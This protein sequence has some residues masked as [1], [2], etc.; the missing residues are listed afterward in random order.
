VHYTTTAE[1]KGER[2][3]KIGQHL[4][5]LW[6]S[7][8]WVFFSEHSV[9]IVTVDLRTC[10]LGLSASE[11]QKYAVVHERVAGVD[12]PTI[13]CSGA[14]RTRPVYLS[15]SNSI[16][17]DTFGGATAAHGD[18]TDDVIDNKSRFLLK[19]QGRPASEYHVRQNKPVF[20]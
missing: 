6:A 9:V 12:R 17:I 1:S 14:L 4:P 8:K 11:C 2:N 16:L 18:D 13:I 7:I 15:E 20:R 5:K 19:Y 10:S 3:L